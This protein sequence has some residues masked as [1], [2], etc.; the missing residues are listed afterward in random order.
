MKTK[1]ISC[2]LC[3][4]LAPS[5]QNLKAH[6]LSH[7]VHSV[8]LCDL[9]HR[10]FYQETDVNEHVTAHLD[11][12]DVSASF[13]KHESADSVHVANSFNHLPGD[14]SSSLVFAHACDLCNHAFSSAADL[15]AHILTHNVDDEDTKTNIISND[16][17]NFVLDDSSN[18]AGNDTNATSAVPSAKCTKSS[19]KNKHKKSIA[20]SS[21]KFKCEICSKPF[22]R[23]A[24]LTKHKAS[25]HGH[26]TAS[27][28]AETDQQT[29]SHAVSSV[30]PSQ[31]DDPGDSTAGSDIVDPDLKNATDDVTELNDSC[32][33]TKTE[34][35]RVKKESAS[36]KSPPSRRKPR[37]KPQRTGFQCNVCNRYMVSELKLQVHMAMHRNDDD[38][39]CRECDKEFK[40]KLSLRVHMEKHVQEECGACDAKFD[41]LK[42]LDDHMGTHIDGPK[43]FQCDRCDQSFYLSK[44]LKHHSHNHAKQF[45]VSCQYCDK[46][47]V[48]RK[49]LVRHM[50]RHTGDTMDCPEC[51]KKFYHKNSFKW[52][53]RCH[54]GEVPFVCEICAKSYRLENSLKHHMQRQHQNLPRTHKCTLCPKTFY[55]NC[56]LKS[57]MAVH[58]DDRPFTCEE[59]GKSFKKESALQEHFNVHNGVKKFICDICGYCTWNQSL[60]RRHKGRHRTS[61]DFR[62]P[63]CESAFVCRRYLN[64]HIRA[65]HRLGHLKPHV[66]DQC[67]KGFRTRDHLKRH[68]LSHSQEQPYSCDVCGRRYKQK[69]HLEVHCRQAHSLPSIPVHSDFSETLQL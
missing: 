18:S 5:K 19:K 56:E 23:E 66:C 6:I 4:D 29:I 55:N 45:P 7:H 9:C 37:P 20:S 48:N 47:C 1:P 22:L 10:I 27:D 8:F 36:M 35:S 32:V 26:E 59:C 39:K 57:H 40:N 51:G 49:T 42:S 30:E 14:F 41:D 13:V 12:K 46:V 68:E 62:C 11:A 38:L 44:M 67:G 28:A 61:K 21:V 31:D 24:W 43:Q 52:H 53:M 16:H 33:E 54:T 34:V 15:K 69:C 58:S 60:L 64:A 65:I 3:I 25:V 50:R 63:E 17:S 2:L